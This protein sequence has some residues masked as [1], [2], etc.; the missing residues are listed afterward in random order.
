MATALNTW[1]FIA[2]VGAGTTS[3]VYWSVAGGAIQ[4]TTI[5]TSS[6]AAGNLFISADGLGDGDWPGLITGVRVWSRSLTAAEVANESHRLT[7]AALNGLWAQ[8]TQL[9]GSNLGLDYS[10][11]GRTATVV[12]TPATAAQMPPAPWYRNQNVMSM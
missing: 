6:V 7:P 8:Y 2:L 5:E 3:T 10:G 1:V 9:N 4:S 12:G 11:N